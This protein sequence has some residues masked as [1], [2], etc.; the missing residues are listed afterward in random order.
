MQ[1][2]YK[3]IKRSDIIF[4]VT[5]IYFYS[6]PSQMK[7]FIDRCQVFWEEKYYKDPNVREKTGF[8]IVC[9]EMRR[10]DMFD[11]VEKVVRI[12]YRTIK[13]AFAGKYYFSGDFNKKSS[14]ILEKRVNKLLLKIS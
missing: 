7:A 11:C 13:T 12:F 3:E 10:K 2:Y 9:G 4:L 1:K 5:P 6:V 14:V 8:L